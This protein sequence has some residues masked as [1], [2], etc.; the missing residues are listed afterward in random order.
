[1]MARLAVYYV[2]EPDDPLAEAGGAWLGRDAE[3]GAVL[4]QPAIDGIARLTASPRRYG[5]HAT[6]KPPL[7][8]ASGAAPEDFVD[9]ARELGR[10]VAPF[11]AP[12]LRIGLLDGF[13]AILQ[14]EPSDALHALADR[15]VTGLDRFRAP[16][17]EAELARRH[18]ERLDERGR[19]LLQ[20][21]GYPH[22]LERWQFHMTLSERL[23]DAAAAMLPAKAAAHF[24]AAL[25]QPRII[26][27][28]ALC[29]EPEPDADFTLI[30]RIR[31]IGA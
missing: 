25:A 27:S 10:T 28:I 30:E 8:L 14:A 1:M 31:L 5:F 7:R 29:A 21:F 3:S 19:Q 20:C 26:R 18:P 11:V 16:P 9:A 6:L 23:D 15:A 22:V 4:R 17:D 24:A 2:P 12:R 13:L